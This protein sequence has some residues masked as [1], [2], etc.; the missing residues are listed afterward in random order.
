MT[1]ATKSEV[2]ETFVALRPVNMGFCIRAAGDFI[3]EYTDP[4]QIDER[5][6]ARLVRMRYIERRTVPTS[7]VEA[8]WERW[9]RENAP[10]PVEGSEAEEGE[11]STE[12]TPEP[13]A[14]PVVVEEETIEDLGPKEDEEA[15]KKKVVTRR[16]RAGNS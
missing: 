9:E 4:E 16:R 14:E 1:T 5:A 11:T 8:F 12:E 13:E 3:P 15:P 2:T 10:A 6:L 7:E